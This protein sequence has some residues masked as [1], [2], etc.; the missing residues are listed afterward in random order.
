MEYYNEIN[1]EYLSAIR[2]PMRVMK[3]KVEL[4]DKYDNA[5]GYMENYL[6]SADGSITVNLSQGCRRTCSITVI[7]TDR[8]YIPQKDSLFWYNRKFKIYIGLKTPLG[9]IYWFPQGVFYTQSA[10][11]N[12]RQITIDG[13]DKY[14]ML[15][16]ELNSNMC[17]M[18][19]IAEGKDDTEEENNTTTSIGQGVKIV[20]LIRETLALDMGNGYPIDTVEPLIDAV[21]Y[22]EVLYQDV[23]VDEGSYIGDLFDKIASMIGA[24]IYYDVDGHLRVEKI[25]NEDKPYWYTHLASEFDFGTVDISEETLNVENKFDAYNTV[26][27]VTDNTEGFIY[28][29]TAQN[30]NPMSPVNVDAIGI[31]RYKEGT[32]S[33]PLSSSNGTSPSEKCRQQAQYMIMQSICDN[34]SINFNYPVIPH[35]DVDDGITLT[36]EYFGF[37]LK[38]FVVQSMTIN[39]NGEPT[40]YE[41]VNIQ[42]LPFDSLILR[43]EINYTEARLV[44]T[45]AR[46]STKNIRMSEFNL[47]NAN[48][49]GTK[50]NIIPIKKCS[51]TN[52]VN[53]SKVCANLVDDKD[54]TE[55]DLNFSTANKVVIDF[56]FTEANTIAGYDIVTSCSESTDYDMSA[57]KLY[58]KN[59]D[60]DYV[61]LDSRSGISLPTDR[62]K[63]V[64]V[65]IG[66]EIQIS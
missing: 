52:T 50:G 23:A 56:K 59:D 32:Y 25:F 35:I 3:I 58:G 4:L 45:S 62:K 1:Q 17:E 64:D 33:I 26:T 48:E 54:T 13:I 16:G 28:S 43:P 47:Y 61:L 65:T 38:Q 12:G 37:E 44:I 49:D 7:D 21:F 40:N 22:N 9:N 2:R 6:S 20:D 55:I 34:L 36:N 42:W 27:V 41:V 29:Y 31:R 19:Y 63:L 15:N 60:S 66:K 8:K 30:K 11:T 24:Y 46:N 51:S 39:L 53:D 18:K 5:I 14:G 57:W 10:T